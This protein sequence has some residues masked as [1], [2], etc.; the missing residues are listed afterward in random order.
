MCFSTIIPNDSRYSMIRFVL[1]FLF[2]PKHSE[3]LLLIQIINLLLGMGNFL[4][5]KDF[6][7]LLKNRDRDNESGRDGKRSDP[8]LEHLLFSP[9][10]SWSPHCSHT[11]LTVPPIHQAQS[12]LR[13]F[14]LAGMLVPGC[15]HG[16]PM[17]SDRPL[18]NVNISLRMSIAHLYKTTRPLP[19]G[20]LPPLWPSSPPD[21]LYVCL[22]IYFSSPSWEGQLQAGRGLVSFAHCCIYSS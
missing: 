15:P 13:D 16:S 2:S 4:K 10:S 9:P 19:P 1:V 6:H 14:I 7:L 5:W 17:T 12:D 18:P 8:A 11:G 22:F 3:F 21:I 20:Y